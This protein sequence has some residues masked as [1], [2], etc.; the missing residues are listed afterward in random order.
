[1]ACGSPGW[2]GD[3]PPNKKIDF[4]NCGGERSAANE[5][6]ENKTYRKN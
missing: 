3:I 1:M 6:S 5:M 2:P 4:V